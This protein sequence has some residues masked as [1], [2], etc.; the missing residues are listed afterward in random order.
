MAGR[1]ATR[2]T[3]CPATAALSPARHSAQEE[4]EED[5]PTKSG[6]DITPT[7][8]N[9][10]KMTEPRKRTDFSIK[11]ICSDSGES[12]SDHEDGAP[13]AKCS[14][15]EEGGGRSPSPLIPSPQPS[16][17]SQQQQAAQLAMASL[18]PAAA[19][20]LQA[21]R[22]GL[23][24][25]YPITMPANYFPGHPVLLRPE[26]LQLLQQ[27]SAA[28]TMGARAGV[29]QVPGPSP[30]AGSTSSP[31]PS[32]KPSPPTPSL[33][34][35]PI[36]HS[37]DN[38]AELAI[39][40]GGGGRRARKNYK[41]MTRERRVEAN[42]RERSRVHTISAAFESL[43]RAVPSYS[44]NQRLSKLA[45]L[46]IACSYI[47]ALSRLADLDY[48]PDQSRPSFA[49]CVDLCTKTIQAEGRAKRRH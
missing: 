2:D 17:P 16:P 30:S 28:A 15:T 4:E 18:P 46:R 35:T 20:A 1:R 43:R 39:G 31:S 21:T 33:Q 27:H 11:R 3:T 13:P 25:M 24:P 8:R 10:R 44:Y 40:G 38:D 41:N 49:D 36:H 6:H 34:A 7:R 29:S 14:R 5:S 48:S 23:A 42:A 19:L 26:A 37:Y 47:T 9:K 12:I 32:H 45:I 22:E